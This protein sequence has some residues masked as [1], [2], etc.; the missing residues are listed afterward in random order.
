MHCTWQWVIRNNWLVSLSAAWF[1]EASTFATHNVW[2]TLVLGLSFLILTSFSPNPF[3]FVAGNEARVPAWIW[4]RDGFTN[5][6]CIGNLCIFRSAASDLFKKPQHP[7]F[8]ISPD[9][10]CSAYFHLCEPATTKE[11]VFVFLLDSF[12]PLWSV[13]FPASD[14]VWPQFS[15]AK[16]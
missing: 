7:A 2:D 4:K 14:L 3:L 10:M 15:K 12:Q 11:A 9:H 5:G 13:L 6:F 16:T 1:I 8:S